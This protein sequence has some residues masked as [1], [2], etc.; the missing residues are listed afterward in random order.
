MMTSTSP[1]LDYWLPRPAV[2]IS[3]RRRSSASTQ[4][5]WEAASALRLADSGVLGRLVSWRIPGIRPGVTFDEL[6]RNPPF[7]VVC[8]AE[9]TL[10]SGLVGRIW[11]LRRD[12]P[13]LSGA[14]EFREWRK[15]GT[16]RVLFAHW[17]ACDDGDRAALCS[18]ARVEAYGAQG[19]LGVAAVRPLI[20]AFQHRVGSDGIAAAVR[21]AERKS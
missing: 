16:A 20:S 13:E 15:P 14:E 2:R 12:Y 19:R 3:H 9:A 7:T 21:A 1:D 6:F 4:E 10:I 18:E 8:E 11:T 17:V 5:L